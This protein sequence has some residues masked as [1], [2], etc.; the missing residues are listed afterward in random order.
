MSHSSWRSQHCQFCNDAE[1]VFPDMLSLWNHCQRYH[2][3]IMSKN[4]GVQRHSSATPSF[5]LTNATAAMTG[6]TA[7]QDEARK[8]A[9]RSMVGNESPDE[10]SFPELNGFARV[11]IVDFNMLGSDT[12]VEQV[13]ALSE[14]AKS[15]LTAYVPSHLYLTN[16]GKRAFKKK[17]RGG[18]GM[19]KDDVDSAHARTVLSKFYL[20]SED[21]DNKISHFVHE[22]RKLKGSIAK[23]IRETMQQALLSKVRLAD[24]GKYKSIPSWNELLTEFVANADLQRTAFDLLNRDVYPKGTHSEYRRDVLASQL[25]KSCRFVFND[26]KAN[27]DFISLHVTE[28]WSEISQ[29]LRKASTGCAVSAGT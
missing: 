11:F 9:S 13:A 2:S 19:K 27:K 4:P 29:K 25:T 10:S 1:E 20:R 26:A 3:E 14:D 18:K 8:P 12:S 5:A 17:L 28:M 15:K 16:H 6:A 24:N 22:K 7:S 21:A 23:C